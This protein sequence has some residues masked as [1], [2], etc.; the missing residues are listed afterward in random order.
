MKRAEV[1]LSCVMMAGLAVS[2]ASVICYIGRP[3]THLCRAR[4][5]MYAMGFTLCVSSILVKAFRTFL[6]FLPFGQMTN[7]RLHKCYKPVVIIIVITTFQGLI[8]VLWMIFDSPDVMKPTPPPQSMKNLVICCE[9][10]T[11]IGFGIMLSY[12]ALLA[13]FGFL[14]AFKGRKVPQEFSET[15]YIIFSMLMYLFVWMCFIPVYITNN[16][17]GYPVQASAILISSYGIIFCHFIPKCYEALCGS[18]TDTLE[19]ILRRWRVVSGQNL[20]SETD[21]ETYTDVPAITI[22]SEKNGRFSIS[23]TT[24]TLKSEVSLTD[25]EPVIIPTYEEKSPSYTLSKMLGT[26]VTRRR[27]SSI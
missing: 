8:C 14:L 2:F 17:R 23:S 13:F 7:R 4:Q 26:N 10:E 24:T 5:L 16:K 19:R 1:R 25:S 18:K 22:S 3:S 15:G 27:R 20:D 6:A 21:L 9:G 12:I 11:F